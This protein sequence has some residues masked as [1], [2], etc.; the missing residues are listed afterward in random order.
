MAL[1][2]RLLSFVPPTLL[3]VLPLFSQIQGQLELLSDNTYLVSAIPTVDWSP[4]MS[5]TNSAQITIRA[6]SGKFVLTDFQSQL[7]VWTPA[8]PIIA[9]SEAPQYDY[10]SFSLV[11]PVANVTYEN[12]SPIPLFF[13][14][15]QRYLC[16]AGNHRYSHR[17]VHATQLHECQHRQLLFDHRRRHWPKC[18]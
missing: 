13:V 5:V 12:G 3:F 17:S 14:P 8:N 9:P 7:G 15:Q 18:L 1:C 11:S 4:P 2:K 10:Y 6:T 16:R